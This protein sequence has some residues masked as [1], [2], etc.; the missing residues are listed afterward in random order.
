MANTWHEGLRS[1]V[2]FIFAATLPMSAAHAGI[3]EFMSRVAYNTLPGGESCEDFKESDAEAAVS[4]IEKCVAPPGI[5]GIERQTSTISDISQEILRTTPPR[6]NA[7]DRFFGLLGRENQRE[8]ICAG[9]FA[10]DLVKDNEAVALI[11]QRLLA[12]RD[13]KQFLIE[14]ARQ[15]AS[16]RYSGPRVCPMT[17]ED[18]QPNQA[19]IQ[20]LGKDEGYELCRDLIAARTQVQILKDSIPLIGS[21]TVF[22]L[23]DRIGVSRSPLSDQELDQQIKAAYGRAETAIR[24]DADRVKSILQTKGG[25]GFNRAE[26]RALMSDQALVSKVLNVSPSSQPLKALACDANASYGSGADKFETSLLVGS[27]LFGGAVGIVARTGAAATT[28][29]LG[30]QSARTAGLL[31]SSAANA[32]R[33]AALFSLGAGTAVTEGLTAIELIDKACFNSNRTEVRASECVSAPRVEML[34][35]DNCVVAAAVSGLGLGATAVAGRMI[36]R[37]ALGTGR[38]AGVGRIGATSAE[39]AATTA[40]AAQR[41]SELGSDAERAVTVTR[42]R[43]AAQPLQTSANREEFK[44]HYL[45][46]EAATLDDNETWVKFATGEKKASR[47]VEIEN[48]KLRD[49][50]KTLQD[51]DLATALT[52]RHK[53]ITMEEFEALQK[54]YPGIKLHPY[55]D[56]KSVRFAIE[57][58]VPPG[59]D[60]D[61]QKTFASIQTRFEAD[62]KARNLVRG[63]ENPADWFRA[64]TGE[65]GDQSAL[66]ARWAREEGS[67]MQVASFQDPVVRA[68]LEANLRETD[69]LREQAVAVAA[70]TGMVER[71]ADGHKVLGKDVMEIMRKAKDDENAA[72]MLRQRYGLASLT[73]EQASKLRSYAAAADKFSPSLYV[74]RREVATLDEADM[75]GFSID[76]VG[77]GASNL[78]STANALAGVKSLDDAILRARQAEKDV[79]TVFEGRRRSVTEVARDLF[80]ADRVK[81]VCSGDD[82]VGVMKSGLSE[83]EKARLANTL[84]SQ[85]DGANIRMA[86]IPPYVNDRGARSILATH[87]ESVEKLMRTE[88]VGKMENSRLRGMLFAID[89]RSDSPGTGG[90]GLIVGKAPNM[91]LS[92]SEERLV[93]EAFRKAVG[94]LNDEL[95]P[96]HSTGYL[97]Y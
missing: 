26:R 24:T 9:N 49:L 41:N 6:G 68:K 80:G 85:Q 12:L 58:P 78:Q 91:R 14:K 10:R 66:V 43:N 47:F 73:P 40:G 34:A 72:Y 23:A 76:F 53:E 93:R 89:V 8:L 15:L 2:L 56:Y 38:A 5:I 62:I 28:I 75:G 70:D 20:M 21:P 19:V 88:L 79:T 33:T 7:E 29:S 60:A 45:R 27:L 35:R 13:S 37:E 61:L 54:K 18:L 67:P 42:R 63:D 51:K 59:F 83:T 48:W 84:A 95:Y 50:N 64:A 82:C 17:I 16:P 77:M 90:M 22:D 74:T 44:A 3:L 55:S 31:S 4:D 96:T 32:T 52:N 94:K 97:V 36:I 87:G 92:P 71:T 81:T 39:D 86:Y 46:Y 11:R 69:R 1:L 25:Q 57:G 65:T 30:V